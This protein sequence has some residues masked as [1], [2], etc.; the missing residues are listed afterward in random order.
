MDINGKIQEVHFKSADFE[1]DCMDEWNELINFRISCSWVSVFFS[2]GMEYIMYVS[3]SVR[4]NNTQYYLLS[5]EH[6]I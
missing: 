6:A 2:I 5:D 4:N 1:R 3:V